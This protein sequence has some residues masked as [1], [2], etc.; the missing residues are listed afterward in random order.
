MPFIPEEVLL[1]KISMRVVEIVTNISKV[2]FLL[3]LHSFVID[4]NMNTRDK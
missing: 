1:L 3:S 4:E 2:L